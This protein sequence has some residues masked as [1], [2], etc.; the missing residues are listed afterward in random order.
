[1]S[2]K[3]WNKIFKSKSQ[4]PQ[5]LAKINKRHSRGIYEEYQQ[6][7]DLLVSEKAQLNFCNQR[8]NENE[9]G[10]GNGCGNGSINVFEQQP[11]KSSFNSLQLIEAQQSLPQQQQQH[12]QP[13]Q[14]LSTFSR[15]RNTF[16]LKRNSNG[17]SSNSNNKGKKNLPNAKSSESDTPPGVGAA[18]PTEPATTTAAETNNNNQLQRILIVVNKIDVLSTNQ[19]TNNHLHAKPSETATAPA[20]KPTTFNTEAELEAPE[21]GQEEE[22]SSPPPPPLTRGLPLPVPEIVAINPSDLTPCPCCS[23]TF[24]LNALRKHVVV[25]EKIS[26]KRNT[27]D[28]SRQRREGTALS[29]YVLPK[30]FGLPNAEKVSGVHTPTA[31]SRDPV[32]TGSKI[33]TDSVGSPLPIRR[34]SQT[35]LV[36][37][38]ARASVRRAGGTATGTGAAATSPAGD[39][40]HVPARDRSLAKRI[41]GVASEHCPHCERNFNVKAFDR[42]VEWCKEK[43]IQATI[44]L[45]NTQETSKAKE[46]LDARKQYRPP[47]L[48]TKRSINRN[49]YSGNHEDLL[50]AGDMTA[51]KQSLM[52]LPSMTSS[53]HSDNPPKAKKLARPQPKNGTPAVRSKAEGSSTKVTQN[54][55]TLCVTQDDDPPAAPAPP[56]ERVLRAKRKPIATCDRITE[57]MDR[58]RSQ[59]SG[60]TLQLDCVEAAPLKPVARLR[61]GMTNRERVDAAEK[62]MSLPALKFEDLNRLIKRKDP[63]TIVKATK[64]DETP[65]EVVKVKVRSSTSLVRQARRR[66]RTREHPSLELRNLEQEMTQASFPSPSSPTKKANSMQISTE[67]DMDCSLVP[68]SRRPGVAYSDYEDDSPRAEIQIKMETT[69][70]R[71]VCRPK[72]RTGQATMEMNSSLP[73]RALP[74][75]Q[76]QQSLEALGH[77]MSHTKLPRL[78]LGS[79]RLQFERDVIEMENESS[80][81]EWSEENMM[82]RSANILERTSS[83]NS[84]EFP[85]VEDSDVEAESD[86]PVTKLPLVAKQSGSRIS[87]CLVMLEQ[88]EDGKMYIKEPPAKDD[89]HPLPSS[90]RGGT[91]KSGLSGV[92]V[93]GDKYDPFLSAK[94]QL[95]E[96]CSPGTPPEQEEVSVPPTATL[97]ATPSLSMTTSLTMPSSKAPPTTPKPTPASNFRRTSSL[98][99]PRRT[100]LLPSRPLFATNYRPTIQRG[101]SDEGPIS[102]N[103]LKPEEYDEMPV[104][105]ACVNDFHSPRVVRRDTS[106]SN[107]KQMLKLPVGVGAASD[108]TAQALPG[109][110]VAKT[111]S[112]AVF[113]KYEHELEELN[114]K[115]AE[116]AAASQLTSKELKDKSNNLSKQNSAKN[117]TTSSNPG[118]LPPLTLT[119]VTPSASAPATAPPPVSVSAKENNEKRVPNNYQPIATPLRLEPI[120]RPATATPSVHQPVSGVANTLTPIKLES[121]FGF[122]RP[123]AAGGGEFIDPKLIN[124][125][126]NLHVSSGVAS[127]ASSTPQQLSQSRSR[128]SSQSTITYDRRQSGE[129]RNLLKRKMRLGRNQF[130]YDA[131]P[132]DGDASSGCSADDEANRSSMEYDEQ[133]W[134]QQQKQLL[135]NPLPLVM[136]MGNMPTFDDFDFEEFLSSFE[137]ENDD[138]QFPLFKDCREFLL[139]RTTSRQRSFQKATSTPQ[140]TTTATLRP[141]TTSSILQPKSQPTKDPHTHRS[142]SNSSNSKGGEKLQMQMQ[143]QQS[144]ASSGSSHDEKMQQMPVQMV[145][146][147]PVEDQQKREIFISIETETNA[148]GRSPISPDSLR[149]MV[150]N[151]QTPIDVL[152]IENGNEPE[153]ARFRKISDTED[154]YVDAQGGP[155]DRAS[156]LAGNANRLALLSSDSVQVNNAKNLIQQMQS[157]FRQLGEDAGASIRT[158]FI[159]RPEEQ[160]TARELDPEPVQQLQQQEQHQLKASSPLTPSASADSDE[161][162]SLDGYPM[163]SSHSSRRGASSKL[164]SDSAYGSTNSPY[165]LSRQRSGDLQPGTPRNQNLLRPHTASAKLPSAMTD[166]ST[167]A[168]TAYGTL[169]ARQRL[170][171]GGGAINSIGNGNTDGAESSSGSEH[172]LTMST[173]QPQEQQKHN[174]PDS[175]YNYQQQQQ[176][177]QSQPVYNN[178]N[179]NGQASLTPTASQHSLLSCNS[180]SSLSS[181]MKMSKF[182]HECGG[183]F[184]IEHAKFCM[185]CGVRRMIL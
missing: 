140:Q 94:R 29:T 22:P 62:E 174:R 136:P 19:P 107:R 148:H 15:V 161:L 134:Q 132:E 111:D 87:R 69:T 51:P 151:S 170:Y 21:C 120:S 1:M 105:A 157:E 118:Q 32:G 90:R 60:E 150:G 49:K 76:L 12:Q 128:S 34:N 152:H 4:K 33:P 83:P 163:S 64:M 41:K 8:E 82:R 121:I 158:L 125:C 180:A 178:N 17:S 13:Q 75:P 27:F 31:G 73:M 110:N 160:G 169:K 175:N 171:G 166:V 46:R 70:T 48:K 146:K 28:S 9:N 47:N 99:G 130:L 176:Q 80:E 61:K 11:L 59:S 106:T 65:Q 79:D 109:R 24:N 126:D 55:V 58:L 42:H 147:R 14:Q 7:N 159:R 153:H 154:A 93:S 39:P 38:T 173:Q 138:E 108:T 98:R 52:S 35:D 97:T 124:A 43:A 78:Q 177:V 165:S 123:A 101:L 184:I 185:E 88:D 100:P 68:L 2:K 50:E 6:L 168:H 56:K 77:T 36:R 167:Q 54:T 95:E 53:V 116:V 137:N 155:D 40:N 143:R 74:M 172:S 67:D 20:I 37:S 164:S 183:R 149:H 156:Q 119:T 114:A 3:M 139:N 91:F 103:F 182:C 81:L 23:R 142:N 127:D 66:I 131:S 96:L 102:T 162:S 181:S 117:L 63:T 141:A 16:S 5:P 85:Q 71:T 112:L 25:C 45:A 115:A 84:G 18:T 30:N 145:G 10:N 129:A 113:L 179:N 144:N 72:K 57:T 92:S 133:C 89:S 44:K 86:Q 104:R 26:K 135:A 122:G